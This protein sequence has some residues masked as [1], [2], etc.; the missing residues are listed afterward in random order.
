LSKETFIMTCCTCCQPLSGAQR[1]DYPAALIGAAFP[2]LIEP[3]VFAIARTLS[4]DYTGGSWDF[5]ALSNGGFYM[6]PREQGAFHVRCENCAFQRSWTP[7][8]A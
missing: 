4:S 8:S 1:V 5:Y 7:V 2:L 3:V 6:A